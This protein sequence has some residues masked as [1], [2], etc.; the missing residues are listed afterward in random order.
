MRTNVKKHCHLEVSVPLSGS[1]PC[2]R[3]AWSAMPKSKRVLVLDT[4]PTT[5]CVL[6]L[7]IIWMEPKRRLF[8]LTLT[9]VVAVNFHTRLLCKLP[10]ILLCLAK[11][12]LSSVFG[13]CSCT[14]QT[15]LLLFRVSWDCVST[16][17]RFL[18]IATLFRWQSI[19][20]QVWS[21]QLS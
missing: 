9:S 12:S 3:A 6:R 21:I 17:E 8:Q 14:F 19:D 16:T 10:F 5:C 1:W 13:A 11:L 20:H 7:R 15:L 18:S 4:N 2:Q